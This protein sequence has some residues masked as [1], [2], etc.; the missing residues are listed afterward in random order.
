M[1]GAAFFSFRSD[2]QGVSPPFCIDP[3]ELLFPPMHTVVLVPL[4][5]WVGEFSSSFSDF[6]NFSTLSSLYALF[7]RLA[8]SMN[9]PWSKS[10]FEMGL[11][12]LRDRN[13]QCRMLNILIVAQIGR[14]IPGAKSWFFFSERDFKA[15]S[16]T[17]RS[18]FLASTYVSKIRWYDRQDSESVPFSNALYVQK[19]CQDFL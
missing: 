19:N 12:Y 8:W 1:L 18:L 7:T 5:S 6:F 2:I 11:P 10:P 13:W 4:S 3:A 9:V 14:S 17:R 15:R 16:A